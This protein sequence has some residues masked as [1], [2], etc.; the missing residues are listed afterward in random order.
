ML[1]FRY[2]AL[3]AYFCGFIFEHVIIVAYGQ[4]YYSNVQ[5]GDGLIFRCGAQLRNENKTKITK[6]PRYTI[7]ES[8]R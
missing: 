1:N 4:L 5:M 7:L 2:Q 8:T 6:I 3:K